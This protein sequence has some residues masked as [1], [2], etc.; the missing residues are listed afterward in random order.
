MSKNFKVGDKVVWVE[1]AKSLS[2]YT[3]PGK[4]VAIKKIG[5]FAKFIVEFGYRFSRQKKWKKARL[6][7]P[8]TELVSPAGAKI[9]SSC[10][11]VI[12]SVKAGTSA[13]KLKGLLERAQASLNSKNFAKEKKEILT[14]GKKLLKEA[15]RFE[16]ETKDKQKKTQELANLIV[17]ATV[18]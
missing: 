7:L 13:L 14:E 9:I 6:I 12:F 16:K 18:K 3:K 2:E 5:A 15:Q 1:V 8:A 17:K 11:E 4:I 10:Q